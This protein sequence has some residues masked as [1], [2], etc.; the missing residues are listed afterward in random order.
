MRI[1][2]DI[3]ELNDTEALE[4]LR[5]L[6]PCKYNYIDPERRTKSKVIG[7]IAQEVNEVLPDAVGLYSSIIPN[8]ISGCEI[9][10]D[11]V[12]LQEANKTVSDLS[13]NIDS[14]NCMIEIRGIDGVDQEYNIIEIIDEN[15]IRIDYTY[16]DNELGNLVDT[17]NNLL[18]SNIDNRENKLGLYVVGTKVDDFHRIK[19]DAI[20]TIATAALQEVDRQLQAEKAKT[21]SLETQ[22][23]EEKAK[24]ATLESQLADILQRLS[25]ANL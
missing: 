12:Y 3:E 14:S 8:I 13:L 23:Q 2:R 1:K 16:N 21:A 5:L 19:K 11:I 10:N 4:K 25:N 18:L 20:F 6:K 22:M 24:V 15:T 7:F 9:H 17:S